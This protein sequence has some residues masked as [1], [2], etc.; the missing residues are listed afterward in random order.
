MHLRSLLPAVLFLVGPAMLLAGEWKLDVVHLKNGTRLTGLIVE[1]RKDAVLFKYVVRR[2]GTRTL[3][4]DTQLDPAEISRIDR[5]PEPER[6]ELRQRLAQLDRDGEG[7]KKRMAAVDLRFEKASPLGGPAWRYTGQYFDLLSNAREDIVRRVI[8]RL[9]DIFRA[10]TERLGTRHRPERRTQVVLYKT[11][12]EYQAALKEAGLKILNPAYYDPAANRIVAASD[13]ERWADEL[14][15]LRRKHDQVLREL[16][17]QEQKLRRHFHGQPPAALVA[18]LRDIR[19]NIQ[20]LNS[21]NE[22]AFER[23]HRPLFATLFHEAFHAYLDNYVYPSATHAVPRWLNEGLAQIFETALV[24]TGELRIGHVDKDRLAAVQEAVRK[25]Q[26]VPLEELLAA[27]PK[28]FSVAHVSEAQASDR[29]FQTAWALAYYLTF[30]R[31]LLGTKAL[32]AYVE[33]GR[34]GVAPVAAFRTLVG[35]PLPEFEAE[36]HRYILRLL[37]DGTLKSEPK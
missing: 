8:V 9:E 29:Y 2:A 33:S 31:K 6:K 30:D 14:D 10:Y 27:E 24:E 22:A 34:R 18:Q 32:D 3:V 26:L 37:P 25:K 16:E 35:Q 23:L 20:L 11:R 13:L 4:I 21:E 15:E 17:D 5:L 1:E 7:E 19:R 28:H 12:P 36:F